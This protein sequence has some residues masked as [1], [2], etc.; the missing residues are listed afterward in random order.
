MLVRD[1]HEYAAPGTIC[2]SVSIDGNAFPGDV[3]C[4]TAQKR[5]MMMSGPDVCGEGLP[6]EGD[7]GPLCRPSAGVYFDQV[8]GGR[9]GIPNCADTE[10]LAL[11]RPRCERLFRVTLPRL[12]TVDMFLGRRRGR[13][14]CP[15]CGLQGV[16]SVRLTT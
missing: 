14:G 4:A 7:E 1:L 16:V 12:V 3:L 8:E 9:E 10:T 6:L 5:E 13:Q 15:H 2:G 11:P